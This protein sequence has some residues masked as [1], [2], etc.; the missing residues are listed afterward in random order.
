MDTYL[1]IFDSNLSN[2]NS[3]IK[4]DN[5]DKLVSNIEL[6]L[7]NEFYIGYGYDFL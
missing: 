1:K 6:D 5:Q 7:E 3:E 2:L 4:P